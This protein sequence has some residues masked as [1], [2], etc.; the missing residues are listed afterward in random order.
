M[1]IGPSLAL[2]SN[3]TIRFSSPREG[4]GG[5]QMR[6]THM[7]D[8]TQESLRNLPRLFFGSGT[9]VEKQRVSAAP[10]EHFS[11]FRIGSSALLLGVLVA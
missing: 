11:E 3:K 4:V 6:I 2:V 7:A 10:L 8:E 1:H 9:Y 5:T